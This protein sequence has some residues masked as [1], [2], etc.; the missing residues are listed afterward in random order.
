MRRKNYGLWMICILCWV[1]A[2][3]S[4]AVQQY[5]A[6]EDNSQ[7]VATAQP[8]LP[9]PGSVV[10]QAAPQTPVAQNP[11]ATI[12][13]PPDIYVTPK[14]AKAVPV[15]PLASDQPQNQQVAN[16]LPSAPAPATV[17][18]NQP[19]SP[20]TQNVPIPSAPVTANSP[21]VT[22]S[23]RPV[24]NAAVPTQAQASDDERKIWFDN[25]IGAVK[26]QK[27]ARYAQEFCQ[28]GWDRISDAQFPKALL[29]SS[30]PTDL[31]KAN[32]LL[33][34]ISQECKIAVVTK[35]GL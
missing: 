26:N 20:L 5:V 10:A 3:P 2:V 29:I 34:T 17:T 19:T 24:T 14:E 25:C 23:P 31:K 12:P 27:L 32:A 4:W 28:C 1:A 30:N 6:G 15:A 21:Q 33:V 13:A 11:P 9:A 18:E 7:A 22:S 16:P 8:T 35:Y